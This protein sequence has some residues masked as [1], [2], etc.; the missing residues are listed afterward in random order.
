MLLFYPEYVY[1][2]EGK[3]EYFSSMWSQYVRQFPT[4]AP[5]DQRRNIF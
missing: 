3:C 1:C 2:N 5:E 4:L